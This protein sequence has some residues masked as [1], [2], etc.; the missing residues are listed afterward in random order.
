[1]K[2][3]P[4]VRFDILSVYLIPHKEKEFVHFEGAFGWSEGQNDE[5]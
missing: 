4:P 2:A 3:R 1:M 5:W